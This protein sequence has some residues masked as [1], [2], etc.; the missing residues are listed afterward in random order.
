MTSIPPNKENTLTWLHISDLHLCPEHT[1]WDTDHVLGDLTK[2]LCRLRETHDG[3]SPDLIFVT[4]DIAYGAKPGCGSMENQY[5]IAGLFLEGLLKECGIAKERLFLVPGNHDVDKSRIL[6]STTEWLSGRSLE[7]VED[8]LHC[9]NPDN[10]EWGS[11]EKRMIQYRSFVDDILIADHIDL[12]S[13]FIYGKKVAV[14]GL[15][16]GIAGFNTA[17]SSTGNGESEKGHLWF[18]G[19]WQS[20]FLEKE[21]KDCALT[22]GLGHHPGNWFRP[23][24][25]PSV[26]E[27]IKRTFDFY[28]HGH[29]HRGWLENDPETSHCRVAA[30]AV[31]VRK[32]KIGQCSYNIV[33]LDLSNSEIK[34]GT[35]WFRRYDTDGGG[36]WVSKEIPSKTK[37]DGSAEFSLGEKVSPPLATQA[38]G[39]V[40]TPPP[41]LSP[42]EER[43]VYGR[44]AEIRDLAAA[45]RTCSLV[46]VAGLAGIGKTWIINEVLEF[47]LQGAYQIRRFRLDEGWGIDELYSLMAVDLGLTDAERN[48]LPLMLKSGNWSQLVKK[49]VKVG[50]V[51]FHLGRADNLFR[52]GRLIDQA[53]FVFFKIITEQV[54]NIRIVLEGRKAPSRDL[55]PKKN[56]T[57]QS[58]EGL[59]M[60]AVQAFFAKPEPVRMPGVGWKLNEEEAQTIFERLG[61]ADRK[62]TM[63]HPLGMRLLAVLAKDMNKKPLEVLATRPERLYEDLEREL[64]QELF[65]YLSP[66]RQKLLAL[67][68][69][70]R[71]EIPDGHVD[72]LNTEVGEREGFHDLRERFLIQAA[73]GEDYYYVHDLIAELTRRRIEKQGQDLDKAHG[74]IA[75]LWLKQVRGATHVSEPKRRAATEALYHILQSGRYGLIADLPPRM[76]RAGNLIRQ[77]QS[78]SNQLFGQ[79][80]FEALRN[81]LEF[82]VAYDPSDHKSHRFL[83]ETI[84]RL[85]GEGHQD[86]YD[87]HRQAHL[88]NQEFP[89]YLAN[90]GRWWLVRNEPELFLSHLKS[91]PPEVRMKAADDHVVAIQCLC[92]EKA[93]QSGEASILRQQQI[94][95]KSNNA[96]FYNDEAQYLLGQYE[97][98]GDAQH[99]EKALAI[100]AKAQQCGAANNYTLAIQC[101]CLEKAGKGGEA[102]ILRQQQ[103]DAKSNNAAFYNDEAQ[104]L[105]GQYGADGDAQH[106]EKALAILAKAQQCGAADNYTLAI[107]NKILKVRMCI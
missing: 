19:R 56:Y 68:S 60:P 17:W 74:A 95:A 65:N 41:S 107:Q 9:A 22:I 69:L 73:K 84:E 2:D 21:L 59:T 14:N 37:A 53:I 16:V 61:G 39:P 32:D 99:L 78:L 23:S 89:Q 70:Y 67:A 100:L 10:G 24:E 13:R 105:L 90:L 72:A 52:N 103:I 34:K 48:L 11:I 102:S 55:F 35:I 12:D 80:Q 54:P 71:G 75:E 104:Y 42:S 88:L 91:L 81:V 26:T 8:L 15:Q 43:G 98:D 45:V 47:S 106:L 62:S 3:L 63:A 58:I 5:M 79:G 57:I 40:E 38:Q 29:E 77:I 86:A 1:G 85:E 49:A 50:P 93:G 51:A 4:G 97:A 20:L 82:L 6:T 87:H 36:A 92:L 46:A 18:G 30:G 76:I 64:F 33:R 7:N 94:D 31:Y 44:D 66:G 27:T 25:D 96:V 28:L 101:L 83:G